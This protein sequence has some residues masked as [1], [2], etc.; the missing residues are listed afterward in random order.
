M[1]IPTKLKICGKDYKVVFME[2]LAIDD[3]RCSGTHDEENCIIEL[4]EGMHPDREVI[5]F[6]HEVLHAIDVRN[7]LSEEQVYTLSNGIYQVLKDN[8]LLRE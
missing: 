8:H 2:D 4:M 5:T 7:E 1:R 3:T 6:L